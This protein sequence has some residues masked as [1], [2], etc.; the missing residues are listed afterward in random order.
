MIVFLAIQKSIKDI[1]SLP[2]D[3][4]TIEFVNKYKYIKSK[5]SA[6]WLLHIFYCWCYGGGEEQ[7]FV[8]RF[9]QKDSDWMPHTGL[10]CLNANF[11]Y[12]VTHLLG[13][14]EF[15]FDDLHLKIIASISP[16]ASVENSSAII[17]SF[18]Q[19]K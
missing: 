17:K 6:P 14:G 19:I 7:I 12:Y 3:L 13:R 8:K 10:K 16:K 11:I 2:D 1:T 5:S 4:M 9:L 18:C 15:L